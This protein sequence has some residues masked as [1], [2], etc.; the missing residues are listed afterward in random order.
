MSAAVVL[1]LLTFE[2]SN[3]SVRFFFGQFTIDLK[4]D[5]PRP[6]NR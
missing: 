5:L 3:Q 2:R 4:A 6:C 1:A